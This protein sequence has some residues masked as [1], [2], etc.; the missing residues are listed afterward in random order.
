MA[1]TI[2]IGSS[3]LAL[4]VC[5]PIAILV[6]YLLADPLQLASISIIAI[7]I[8][9]LAIPMVIK[10]HQVLLIFSCNAIFQFSFLPGTPPLWLLATVLA[11]GIAVLNRCIDPARPLYLGGSI[12]H[13]LLAIGVVV[14]VT[15]YLRGG[16]GLAAFGGSSF[17]GKRY[18][19]VMAAIA[20]Y[21]ALASQRVPENRR[22]FYATLFFAAGATNV[23]S[24]FL[25]YG[26]S[27]FAF[28]DKVV[29]PDFN[30]DE[31][32]MSGHRLFFL[33][34]ICSA[35][36]FV[37]T[38]RYGIRGTFERYWRLGLMVLFLVGAMLTG[39]RSAF[40]LLALFY[41]CA[42]FLEGL[43]RT[44]Y[45]FIII[46]CGLI[47]YL[48]LALFAQQLPW[49][50]QRSISFLPIRVDPLIKLDAKGSVD[51]RVDMWKVVLPEV[52]QYFWEGKGY[53]IDPGG[54]FMSQVNSFTQLGTDSSD[55]AAFA[56]DYH[57]GPLSLIIPFGIWGFS[58][59]VWFI[60][61]A[62][63]FLYKNYKYGDPAL[64]KANCVLFAYFI[65]KTISFFFLVGGFYGDLVA[66]TA[67]V[68]LAVS[69]NEDYARA[70][71]R[72]VSPVLTLATQRIAKDL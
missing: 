34:G 62:G 35:G 41:V 6:G 49:Q 69:L 9:L 53:A 38:I 23:L 1:N 60:G 54:M 15:G 25:D 43:H 46:G 36:F 72:E 11:F 2:K 17:G 18:I 7:L 70:P 56:G 67:V 8:G 28:L 45:F 20:A 31:V 5:L 14:I 40:G 19:Y 57:N 10:W 16:A 24:F 64:Q 29:P 47:F 61:A 52:P 33:S 44:R 51:W 42:L 4:F 27:K 22:L 68:G 13:S 63:R 55:W 12:A 50:I 30:T 71:L 58:A 37:M 59:F 21:F 32:E 66:F 39:F 26:G 3:H 48:F 65:A